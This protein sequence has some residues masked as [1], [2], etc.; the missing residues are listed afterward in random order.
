[1]ALDVFDSN[2]TGERMTPLR[3]VRVRPTGIGYP[4]EI[5]REGKAGRYI[6]PGDAPV[7]ARRRGSGASMNRGS[8]ASPS[9][10]LGRSSIL[11][12]SRRT[13]KKK[14]NPQSNMNGLKK[15]NAGIEPRMAANK[16]AHA[17]AEQTE[18]RT[19]TKRNPRGQSMDRTRNRSTAPQA[20]ERLRQA[21]TRKPREKPAAFPH[22]SVSALRPAFRELRRNAS[23]G[24]DGMT[25]KDG[26]VARLRNLRERVHAGTYWALLY[27]R[28]DVPKPDGGTRPPG[29]AALEDKIV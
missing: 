1:M 2:M 16:V 4:V 13:A 21:A 11:P 3:I 23:R 20:V 6:H 27:R 10:G 18:G 17:P 9:P 19:A 26:M 7:A 29:I 25:R 5:R 12:A 8:H 22:L 28:V 15:S 14:R 24:L